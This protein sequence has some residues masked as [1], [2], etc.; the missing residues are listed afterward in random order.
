M[1]T[2]ELWPDVYHEVALVDRSLAVAV[3][4]QP[5]ALPGEIAKAAS[6]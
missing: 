1:K 6:A 5:A 2:G 4:S 3:C